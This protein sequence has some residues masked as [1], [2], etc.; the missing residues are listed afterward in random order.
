MGR[1][2][3]RERRRNECWKTYFHVAS[4]SISVR[5]TLKT[6]DWFEKGDV[7]EEETGEVTIQ[8]SFYLHTTLLILNEWLGLTEGINYFLQSIF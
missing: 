5:R 6:H 4:T 8:A 2:G 1:G 7:E 3:E